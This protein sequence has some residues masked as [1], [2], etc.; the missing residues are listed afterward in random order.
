MMQQAV[1]HFHTLRSEGMMYGDALRSSAF[2]FG[3][4]WLDLERA[5][6]A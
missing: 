6:S 2:R 3:V 1:Q 4:L 5:V